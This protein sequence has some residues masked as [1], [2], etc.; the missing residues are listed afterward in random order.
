MS[1][2]CVKLTRSDRA[3]NVECFTLEPQLIVDTSTLYLPMCMCWLPSEKPLIMF[4][5][6]GSMFTHHESNLKEI[7]EPPFFPSSLSL[8]SPFSLGVM[9]DF[10]RFFC[11]N[12][13]AQCPEYISHW[14]P[15]VYRNDQRWIN[16]TTASNNKK[17]DDDSLMRMVEG[18]DQQLGIISLSPRHRHRDDFEHLPNAS[19]AGRNV[20]L[21]ERKPNRVRGWEKVFHLKLL[22][23]IL[24]T[25]LFLFIATISNGEI[26]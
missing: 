14:S 25:R 24:C 21:L 20:I 11:T 6:F 23:I 4:S 10:F 1:L 2:K 13:S 15:G 26:I 17:R 3:E 8:F 16:K 5:S 12:V 19:P 7:V 9:F 22:I 18:I